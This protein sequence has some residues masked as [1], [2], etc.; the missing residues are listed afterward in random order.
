MHLHVYVHTHMHTH[1]QL[2]MWYSKS[3]CIT[4]YIAANNYIHLIPSG[5]HMLWLKENRLEARQTQFQIS[6]WVRPMWVTFGKLFTFFL[7]LLFRG[8]WWYAW[9]RWNKWVNRHKD[10]ALWSAL[11]IFLYPNTSPVPGRRTSRT[12]NMV[13]LLP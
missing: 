7:L 13:L 1:T 9:Q 2:V 5:E 8:R 3:T 4:H 10:L 11:L 6:N 12:I